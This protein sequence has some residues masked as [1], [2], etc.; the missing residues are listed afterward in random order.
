V[1]APT[2]KVK[3]ARELPTA[4]AQLHRTLEREPN[5]AAT[6]FALACAWLEA[7]EPDRAIEILRGLHSGNGPYRA[8][9]AAKLRDAENMKALP[10]SPEAYVRHLFD[11]FSA[12]YDH[13]MVNDLHYRAPQILRSLAEMLM[14]GFDGP[15]DILDLGCGTGLAG[16]AFKSLANRIDGVDLS[17]LMIE[18]ATARG[19]Y[20]ELAIEN[21]ENFLEN[22]RREYDLLIAAD[23]LVYFGD[24]SRP[25]GAARANLKPNGNFLFTTEKQA[26]AGFSLGP[27]RRYRHSDDY[28]R[29]TAESA[30]LACIGI[31]DCSPRNDAGEP[32]E[33]LAVALRRT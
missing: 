10:R 13:T 8:R 32:V 4:I 33:G 28:L 19:I 14:I 29:M 21:L 18:R 3:T 16:E 15:L 12:S 2:G 20:S 6:A 22:S 7:G 30:G 11:Q 1:R 17:P 5:S 9:A 24:L 31:L 25:F 27:K 23:T 26:K